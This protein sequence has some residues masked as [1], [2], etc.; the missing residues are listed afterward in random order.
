MRKLLATSIVALVFGVPSLM[1]QGIKMSADFLPLEVG[2][3]W[4]YTITDSTGAKV[5]EFDIQIERH[6][7][8]DGRSIYLFTQFPI[9]PGIDGF[10]PLGIRYDRQLNQYMRFDGEFED[11]LFPSVGAIVKVLETDANDLP[12]RVLFDFQP[13]KLT[14]E[15]S[16]GIVEATF[17]TPAGLQV[18]TLIT[19]RVG[20]TVIGEAL[21]EEATPAERIANEFNNV[22]DVSE[23]NP[24]IELEATPEGDGHRFVLRV[25][26]VS[27]KLLAFDFVSSQSFDFAVVDPLHGQEIWRWSRRMFFSSVL[28]SEAIRIRGEW[29]FEAV[30]NHRDD[31]LNPVEPGTYQ[32]VAFL[33]AETPIESEPIEIQILK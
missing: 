16:V 8:L 30:W 4:R 20:A 21:P 5:D 33:T 6:T 15:R 31:D 12:L 22:A 28:R 9:A 27:D 23:A 14:L 18:A 10:R 29:L 19:A 32:V 17:E 25:S 7:I 2:N 11:D 26:N 13:L 1:G 24:I 3:L